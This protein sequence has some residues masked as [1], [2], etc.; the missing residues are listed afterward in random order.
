MII[1]LKND[2]ILKCYFRFLC[3][4]F[5]NDI[6]AGSDNDYVADNDIDNVKGLGFCVSIKHAVFMAEEFNKAGIPSIAL[7][8]NSNK[9]VRDN[10][11][12]NLKSRKLKIT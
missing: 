7:T 11:S 5:L 9:E 8:G 6:V 1:N 3:L 2:F 12:K 10:V 4:S